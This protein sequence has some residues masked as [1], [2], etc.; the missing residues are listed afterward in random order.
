MDISSDPSER[1]KKVYAAEILNE[2]LFSQSSGFYNTLYEKNLISP[3]LSSGYEHTRR[4]SFNVIS[5]E[6]DDPEAVYDYFVKYI[7]KAKKDGLDKETFEFSKR[8]VYASNI[9]SFDSTEEIA[10]NMVYNLFDGA[11]ILDAPDVIDSITLEYVEKI[12]NDMYKE[13]CY[14]MSVVDPIDK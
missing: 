7:E 11:D 4:C 2:M 6:S 12:L 10:N 5:S 1:M 13:E 3:D 8:T 9:K 14:A